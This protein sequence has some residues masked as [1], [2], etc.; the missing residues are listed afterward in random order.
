M[1]SLQKY[2][3]DARETNYLA[4]TN[5]LQSG[6]VSSR[7]QEL[8]AYY[9]NRISYEEVAL[10][11]E[12][13]SGERLLSDQKIGQI[14]SDKAL[15]I[16]QEICKITKASLAENDQDVLEVNANVNI[17]NSEEKE[18]LLFDD[19]IQCNC[20]KKQSVNRSQNRQIRAK[21]F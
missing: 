9:S 13:I 2:Q 12:R 21:S 18:I 5:Q 16:S 1:F 6:Y 19:G 15:K 8:C 3:F 14:V 4:L 17:Y 7:L 10:L 20:V 11:V